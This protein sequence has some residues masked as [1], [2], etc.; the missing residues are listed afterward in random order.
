[1]VRAGAEQKDGEEDWDPLSQLLFTGGTHHLT[2]CSHILEQGRDLCAPSL[3][4]RRDKL[5]EYSASFI[6]AS[7]GKDQG[8]DQIRWKR[9]ALL[10]PRP[11]RVSSTGG[12]GDC[13]HH[14]LAPG[15]RV[16]NWSQHGNA[17]LP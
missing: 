13:G 7:H 8:G 14:S 12:E 10:K 2:G 1:M 3:Q 16:S 9:K 11:G 6:S 17:F 5:P 4:K 15:S